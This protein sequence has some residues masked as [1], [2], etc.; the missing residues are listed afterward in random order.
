MIEYCSGPKHPPCL[1]KIIKR[2]ETTAREP[3]RKT[4]ARVLSQ[5]WWTDDATMMT[6]PTRQSPLFRPVFLCMAALFAL[7]LARVHQDSPDLHPGHQKYWGFG[8]FNTK[9]TL[10]A[11][12][13]LWQR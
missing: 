4:S 7:V 9:S 2:K 5:G 1:K 10:P 13:A 11:P 3:E 6:T 12:C 8:A